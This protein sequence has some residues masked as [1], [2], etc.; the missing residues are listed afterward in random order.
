MPDARSPQEPPRT[1]RMRH[2]VNREDEMPT[3]ALGVEMG[4]L[5]GPVLFVRWAR[6]IRRCLES[7]EADGDRDTVEMK[8]YADRHDPLL[9]VPSERSFPIVLLLLRTPGLVYAS[10]D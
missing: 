8:I 2:R 1:Q 3:Q 6:Y 4:R 5:I 9:A 7:V 10:V